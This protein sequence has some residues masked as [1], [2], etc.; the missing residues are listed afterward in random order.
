MFHDDD[1]DVDVDNN[2]WRIWRREKM[3]RTRDTF[4]PANFSRATFL[5]EKKWTNLGKDNTL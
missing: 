3:V 1:A 5:W 2:L 4:A